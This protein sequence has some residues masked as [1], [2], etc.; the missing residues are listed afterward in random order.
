MDCLQTYT[1]EYVVLGLLTQ[2]PY[3]P[4]SKYR[5]LETK[6]ESA[7]KN[8]L[9]LKEEKIQG[10]ESRLEESSSLNQQLRSELTSVRKQ[11]PLMQHINA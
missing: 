3:W 11:Y 10:L 5:I 2:I 4:F 1:V 6:I 7:L 9:K 8:S